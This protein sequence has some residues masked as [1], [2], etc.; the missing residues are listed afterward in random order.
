MST[1]KATLNRPFVGFLALALLGTAAVLWIVQLSSTSDG[2]GLRMWTAACVRVGMLMTALWLA[3]PADGR[4]A[5]WAG[6]SKETLIGFVIAAVALARLQL[7][8]L[9]PLFVL[10]VIIGL[11]LRPRSKARPRRDW[12]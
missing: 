6:I 5:A 3:L 12:R 1:E 4:Q 9:L 7:R 8:V 10:L 11:V 2:A